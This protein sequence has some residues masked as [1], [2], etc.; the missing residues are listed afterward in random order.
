MSD[1]KKPGFD[2][3]DMDPHFF[4]LVLSLSSAAM[5]QLGKVPNPM[6]SKVD[7]NLV[8]AQMTIDILDMIEKKTS[9]NL[10]DKEEKL[11]KNTLSDL[12]LNYA[13]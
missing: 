7:R 4:S 8:Q 12:K 11:I 2:L 13:D 10:S 1:E 6:T 3:T 9:G 5:Q